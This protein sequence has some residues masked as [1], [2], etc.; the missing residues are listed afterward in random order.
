[1]SDGAIV[2]STKLDNAELERELS[3]LKKEIEKLEQATAD[4]EAK[5][6]PLIEQAQAL[7]VKMRDAR[8]EVERYRMAWAAGVAG[9]DK[10]Q[11]A[12]IGAAQRLEVEHAKVVTQIEKIDAKLQPAY[13]K[14]AG[15]EER[16][17]G[18]VRELSKAEVN[19]ER[20]SKAVKRA[21]KSMDRFKMRLREVVRSALVFTLI[22]QSL[23]KFREWTGKV[24]KSNE[25]ASKAVARLK[26]AL[27]VLAQPLVNVIIPAFTLLVNLL[28]QVASAL[29]NV[30]ATIFG[31]TA[32]EAR[33][34]AEGLYEE[35]SALD[36][37]G[38]AAKKA[39]KSLANFDELN[40]LSSDNKSKSD[41]SITPDFSAAGEGGWLDKVLGD[42][43][44]KV[45][46][47]LLL[48]GIALVAIGAATGSLALISSGFFL[49]NAGIFVRAETGTL[50]PWADTLGLNN[51]QE[52]VL[53]AITL[54][55][56]AMVAIG[57]ALGNIL[58][59]FAG[60]GIIW[61]AVAYSQSSGMI[62]SWTE[63]QVSR[64][65][66]YVTGALLLGGIALVAIGA[67]TANVLMVIAGLSLIA[68]G[69]YVGV[70]G[71]IFQN[72]WDALH[73]AEYATWITA[74]LIIGGIAL[75]VFGILLKNILMIF[76]G[77]GLVAAG[78]TVG[79][80]TGTFQ[81]WWE[82][83]Q[84]PQV[85][86]WVT[87]VLL[88]G[89][90]ALTVFGILLKNIPMFLGGLAMVFAG[91]NYGENT[92][93]FDNWW[94]VLGLQQADGWVTAALL[95]GGMALMIVGV[96]TANILMFVG[97]LALL[98]VGAVY[99]GT[100]GTFDSWADAL[101]LDDVAGK[102]TT[103]IMLAGIALIAIGAMTLNPLLILAGLGLLGAG[104]VANRL[105]AGKG[106]SA[107]IPSVQTAHV[108]TAA[109]PSA[110]S[111]S[112]PHLARGAVIPPNREFLAVL[113]DQKSGTNVEAP[114]GLIRQI[115]REEM[116]SMRVVVENHVNFEGDLAQ[117]GRV[118]HPVIKSE[119]KRA[120]DSLVTIG[121][122]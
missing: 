75:V 12:A 94:N 117:L 55:G 77:L 21:G 57:A 22:T 13:T 26:G 111:Y 31:M 91:I 27:L 35:T 100:S 29:A 64:A 51:V 30:A 105:T 16:A 2:I 59:V 39:S 122:Y 4:Q 112:I 121:S 114:E 24:I 78:I 101:H 76:A 79:V 17:G 56:I 109:M 33:E 5:K 49:I 19:S 98:G 97:G 14:M 99:G 108:Q 50:P 60:L 34:A 69:I 66:S 113:G 41:G 119:A 106:S 25:E 95:I 74:G 45:A 6:S 88:L 86:G 92:G 115:I 1:M 110:S 42:A 80:Q 38:S 85:E 11:S 89:G 15:L 65:A 62:G 54:G 48:G 82:V 118:L 70:E 81:N 53:V 7:E 102:V 58:L 28:S 107:S 32:E 96:I 61:T 47:A 104:F 8:A 67:A 44:G 93:T 9:A 103:A 71:G 43:A 37:V 23:A 120:G 68:M 73:L 83:L 63:Q 84:L 18:V 36:G 90:I 87:A 20:M 46:D 52:F 116:G 3:K 10:E 72:W 40:K